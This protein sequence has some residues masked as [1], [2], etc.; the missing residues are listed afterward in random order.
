MGLSSS[1]G[2][3][4]AERHGAGNENRRP[5]PCPCVSR[6]LGGHCEPGCLA[7][8]EKSL[9]LWAGLGQTLDLGF[10]KQAPWAES[11][12]PG[13]REANGRGWSPPT[14][15]YPMQISGAEGKRKTEVKAHGRQPPDSGWGYFSG[16]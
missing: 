12:L 11:T 1:S 13:Q 9:W 7:Q 3:Q 16:V 14:Q 15:L 5:V 8:G 6:A 10:Q 4:R 2:S